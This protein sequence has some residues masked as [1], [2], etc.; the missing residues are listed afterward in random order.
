MPRN[1]IFPSLTVNQINLLFNEFSYSLLDVDCGV[2][3][4][5]IKQEL[6]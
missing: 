2:V 5:G 3:N 1:N 6:N 4:D